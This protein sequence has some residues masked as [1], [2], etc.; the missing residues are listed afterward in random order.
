M[1]EYNKISMEK[2]L[3]NDENVNFISF[4]D[5]EYAGGILKISLK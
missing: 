2:E 1:S 3:L 5:G 4:G